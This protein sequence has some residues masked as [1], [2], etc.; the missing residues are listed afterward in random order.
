MWPR[1]RLIL[2]P[3]IV[4]AALAAAP[5]APARAA[6]APD[7]LRQD[8][9][10]APVG[11]LLPWEGGTTH[12]VTQGEE[13][14]FT[15]N[16]LAAYAYDF[17]M[18][19]ETVVAARSGRV[20]MVYD[21]SDTGGCDPSFASASNYV[22]IDHGDGTSALYLHLERGSAEVKPG[23]I[24]RRGQ[25]IATSGDTGVTCSDDGGPAAHLHFQVQRTD[26]EH[27]F[28]QSLPIAFDDVL[29]NKGVPVE[30]ESYVSANFGLNRPPKVRLAIHHKWRVFAP[31]AVPENPHLIEADPKPLPLSE[32]PPPPQGPST[33]AS[34]VDA[35]AGDAATPTPSRTATPSRTPTP[36]P[37][38]TPPPPAPTATAPPSPS[39]TPPPAPSETPSPPSD[40]PTPEPPTFEPSP[41]ASETPPP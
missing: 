27:Y 6:D 19:F 26:E 18:A 3:A 11:Y 30:G 10:P 35:P 4:F 34:A 41:P 40:T 28:A 24:V 7:R 12:A 25:P 23:D 9:Y 16:G 20:T 29:K 15:H 8:L 22:V 21:G 14:T 31:V 1:F 33:D 38:D 13:T 32:V 5:W 37:S 36:I 17:D 2:V 39:D